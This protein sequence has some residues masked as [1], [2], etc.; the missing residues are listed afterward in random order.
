MLIEIIWMIGLPCFYLWLAGGG[1]VGQAVVPSWQQAETWLLLYT[2]FL[3]L[4]TI[5]TFID[6]DEKIIPDEVTL[7]G[8]IIA[9]LVAAAAPWSR[10]PEVSRQSSQI[11]AAS[12]S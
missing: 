8:T 3:A 12:H 9:L 10:L 1:L 6:F 2:I 5:A 11:A 4:M 7:S